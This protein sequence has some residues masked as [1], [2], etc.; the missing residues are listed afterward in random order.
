MEYKYLLWDTVSQQQQPQNV[1]SLTAAIIKK[2]TDTWK[3]KSEILTCLTQGIILY[4]CKYVISVPQCHKH[5]ITH[6]NT[7]STLLSVITEPLESGQQC[8]APQLRTVALRRIL[9]WSQWQQCMFR[10]PQ[11]GPTWGNP[12]SYYFSSSTWRNASA[13][14]RL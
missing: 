6:K 9:R 13:A 14:S 8:P 5:A 3:W 12:P 11:L 10:I 7:P 4:S 1:S 2:I